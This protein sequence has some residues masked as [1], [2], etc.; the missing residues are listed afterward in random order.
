M[1]RYVII[2]L[3]FSLFLVVTGCSQ[4]GL[5]RDMEPVDDTGPTGSVVDNVTLDEESDETQPATDEESAEEEASGTSSEEE[6][7]EDERLPEAFDVLLEDI[8]VT[9][10]SYGEDEDHS[11]KLYIKEEQYERITSGKLSFKAVCNDDPRLLVTLNTHVV[12][13]GPAP[14]NE[15]PVWKLEKDWFAEGRNVLRFRSDT[16]EIYELA[17]ITLSFTYTDGSV[18]EMPADSVLFQPEDAGVKEVDDL[19]I[20]SMTNTVTRTFS[21]N[22]QERLHDLY[23]SFDAA[24]REGD[25]I[26]MLNGERIFSGMPK[27]KGNRLTLPHELL[28]DENELVFIG[29]ADE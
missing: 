1:G 25:V 28:E 24:N 29:M 5:V 10:S 15:E 2:A 19:S 20:V 4:E 27:K 22:E 13:S 7:R 12:R 18:E 8:G 26:V 23:V 17:D 21:L 16:R 9:R 11:L 14:C 3:M 6:P